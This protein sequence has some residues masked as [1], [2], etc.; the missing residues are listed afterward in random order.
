MSAASRVMDQPGDISLFYKPPDQ[1]FL[2]TSSS[3]L[4]ENECGVSMRIANSGNTR[5]LKEP[6]GCVTRD[7]PHLAQL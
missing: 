5:S 2:E 4:G 1:V 3:Y 6:R 7:V